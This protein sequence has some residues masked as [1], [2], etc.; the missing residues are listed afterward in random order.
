M[1]ILVLGAGGTGGFFGGRLFEAG[2]DVTFLVRPRRAEQMRAE[3]LVLRS[4]LGDAQLRPQVVESSDG[5]AFDLVILSNK[6]YDLGAAMDA[7]APAVEEGAA[8]LPL[9]NGMR[10]LDALDARFGRES[11]LGGWCA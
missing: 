9:L 3:G 4:P 6:A 1:R 2:R 8:V 7:I 11:V 10:H 5:G